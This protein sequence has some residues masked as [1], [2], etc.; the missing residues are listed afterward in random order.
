M[1]SYVNYIPLPPSKVRRVVAAVEP[2]SFD[3]IYSP[4]PERVVSADAKASVQRSADR[5]LRAIADNGPGSPA[6]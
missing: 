4:W 2:F 5:Y 6:R 1:H 3:R